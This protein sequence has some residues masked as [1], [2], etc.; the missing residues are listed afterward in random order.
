MVDQATHEQL[1]LPQLLAMRTI[2]TT[3]E[4]LAIHRSP[5][6]MTPFF[7]PHLFP[8]TQALES[9]APDIIDEYERIEA[10]IRDIPAFEDL[11]PEQRFL[12][13]DKCWKSLILKTYEGEASSLGR[14]LCPRTLEALDAIPGARL[15][16][17]SVLEPGKKLPPHRGPYR[18][19]LRCHLGIKIPSQRE[20]CRIR[21]GKEWRSWE[22][23]KVLV[24]DDSYDHEVANDTNERRVVLFIDFVRPLKVP[25]DTI[26]RTILKNVF[27]R[28]EFAKTLSERQ[29]GW[30][31]LALSP[32]TSSRRGG[33]GQSPPA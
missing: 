33:A 11:S 29:K 26:N 23:G 30:E 13:N 15:A 16:F 6:G 2:Q 20:R 7:E 24:F 3:M 19:I 32:P 17:F 22:K 4:L 21:V 9:A 10:R 8:W 25:F 14:Q 31:E 28:A 12:S 18:G 1:P 5:V 27:D